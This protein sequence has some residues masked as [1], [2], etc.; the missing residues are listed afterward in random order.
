MAQLLELR[1]SSPKCYVRLAL[2]IFGFF[3]EKEGKLRLS[4]VNLT[5]FSRGA[6]AL[7][8]PVTGISYDL[9]MNT[10]ASTSIAR[11]LLKIANLVSTPDETYLGLIY[12]WRNCLRSYK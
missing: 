11:V 10:E 6:E 1:A 12:H 3:S 8:Q 5:Q 2:T 4:L 7:L 9:I